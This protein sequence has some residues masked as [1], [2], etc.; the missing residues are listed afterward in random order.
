M[1]RIP[2]YI[3][4]LTD[5]KLSAIDAINSEWVSNYGKY[6][7]LAEHKLEQLLGV[8]HC[9]LMN[10]GTSA[11]QCLYVALKLKHPNIKTIY[12]PNGVFIAPWNTGLLQYP[13]ETFKVMKTDIQTLNID[14]S[15]E[16]IQSLE[17]N[18]AMV[19]VHNYGNIV[20]VPRL[21]RLRPDIVF[22]EDNCEGLFGK[23][24]DVY[25]GV[26][27][28]CSSCSFYGNKTITSGEGGAFFTNDSEI[29]KYMKSYYSHGMTQERYIHD[30]IAVNYRMTN[31]QAALL[32]D[33]LNDL[34]NIL[35]KKRNII[36]SYATAFKDIPQ[37]HP[38]KIEKGTV[39]SN[40]MYVAIIDSDFNK[41]ERFMNV[42]NI[43]VR[44]LFYDIHDHKH[45]LDVKKDIKESIKVQGFMLPSYPGLLEHEQN[46]IIECVKEFF[47][48]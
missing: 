24:G 46:Y 12:I 47:T 33:Q 6:V 26:E 19:V 41:F 40:W 18:S 15:E 1:N 10:N 29:Y 20:D 43:D 9:I 17:T 35:N 21:K 39:S 3:P 34:D 42:K 44:P 8:K 32:Y 48:S 5:Y 2:I 16:Y 22:M 25:S 7:T 30:K 4:Y 28:L 36:S 37:I 45:L 27:S 11:T 38:L 23:Y 14:T 13:L 31:V